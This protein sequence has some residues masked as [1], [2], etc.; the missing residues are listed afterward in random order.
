[1]K[2][3]LCGVLVV[4]LLLSLAACGS[5]LSGTYKTK[6]IAGT[7]TSYTFK[8]SKLT[9]EVFVLGQKTLTAEGTYKIDGDEI[10]ITYKGDSKDNKDVLSGTQSFEKGDGYIKI[11]ILTLDKQK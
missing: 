9:V 8:G 5:K 3:I 2:K 11:G 10:T 6:E 4:V 1:M 7:Y